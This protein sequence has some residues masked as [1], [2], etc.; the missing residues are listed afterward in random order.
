MDTFFCS[1]ALSVPR[2]PQS[3]SKSRPGVPGSGCRPHIHSLQRVLGTDTNTLP[4]TILHVFA[5]RPLPRS[6]RCFAECLL[7]SVPVPVLRT[8]TASF[9]RVPSS[10]LAV[11]HLPRQG[12]LF[13]PDGHRIFDKDAFFCRKVT[14][15]ATIA[16]HA[17]TISLCATT[18]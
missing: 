2:A 4:R 5:T 16:R 3:F 1:S 6:S 18:V 14:C 7:F 9:P 15:T 13:P 17:K 12:H 8:R 11:F 10:H